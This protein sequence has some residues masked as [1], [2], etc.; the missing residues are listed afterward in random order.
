MVTESSHD[1]GLEILLDDPDAHL[2]APEAALRRLAVAACARLLGMPAVRDRIVQILHTDPN[3]TVRAEAAEVLGT[4]G[5]AA[6]DDLLA[7]TGDPDARVAEAAVTALGEIARPVA[8]ARLIELAKGHS[9]R[10]VNEAA[11]AALGAIG[12][13]QALPVLLDLVASGAPQVRRRAVVA[14]TVFEDPAVEPALRRAAEDRNPMVR[15]VARQ[16]VGLAGHPPDDA[17]TPGAAV[18]PV[19]R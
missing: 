7:A 11:V 2:G 8:V 15:E 14:L 3:A 6:L 16:V 5:A 10:L 1:T 17:G 4:G 13:A 19:S 12:S 9:D 18:Q